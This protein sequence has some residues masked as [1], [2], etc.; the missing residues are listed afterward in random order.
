M[1]YLWYIETHKRQRSN[2]MK[3]INAQ[4]AANLIEGTRAQGSIFTAT[5]T[6]RTTGEVRTM[7][8]RLGVKRGQVG[9]TLGYS[10]KAH[11]LIS[12]YDV[13]NARLMK[14]QGMDDETAAKKSYRMISADALI[15]LTVAGQ[16]YSVY[17]TDTSLLSPQ[18]E[19]VDNHLKA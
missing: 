5:F 1:P 10:P 17:Q 2:D 9:G 14:A 6:K 15:S 18:S 13:E 12:V 3:L 7:Q 19:T 11:D 16:S 4:T 8:A